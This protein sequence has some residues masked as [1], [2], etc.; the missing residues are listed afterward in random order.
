MSRT[1][2]PT[3]SELFSGYL[4]PDRAHPDAFD[5]MFAPDGR[6]RAPIQCLQHADSV[7]SGASGSDPPAQT[8]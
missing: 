6:V 8:D 3:T 4:K 7:G 5:E 2:K 1:A